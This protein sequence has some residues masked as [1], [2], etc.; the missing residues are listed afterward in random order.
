MLI[1]ILGAG[2]AKCEKLAAHAREAAEGLGL[3]VEVKKITD[4][5]EITARG[6]LMTPALVIDGELKS[7][8]KLLSPE[9]IRALIDG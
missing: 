3:D 2:C 5:T 6:V 4:I 9:K 7:S 1:E 8:G